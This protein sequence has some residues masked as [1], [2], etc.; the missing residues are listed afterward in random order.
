MPMRF[1]ML[2][3][4]IPQRYEPILLC[5]YTSMMLTTAEQQFALNQG[6]RRARCTKRI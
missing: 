6:K 1:L 5:K 4:K 3:R 2:I